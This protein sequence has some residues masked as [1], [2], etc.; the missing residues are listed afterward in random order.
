MEHP[1][2]GI[3]TRGRKLTFMPTFL[4]S[5]EKRTHCT[6]FI[7]NP[8]DQATHLRKGTA[9]GAVRGAEEVKIPSPPKTDTEPRREEFVKTG[10]ATT[11]EHSMEAEGPTLPPS[12]HPERMR[13]SR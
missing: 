7:I 5:I 10:C 8:S 6:I 11:F 9:I 4:K 1:K 2:D 3:K 13:L 12:A